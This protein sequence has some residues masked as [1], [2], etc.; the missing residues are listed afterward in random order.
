MRHFVVVS[1][2]AASMA[3]LSAC[4]MQ[5]VDAK[6][7]TVTYAYTEENFDEVAMRAENYCESQY[8]L[9]ASLVDRDRTSSG[10]EATF[11]C[12]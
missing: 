3:V 12:E 8:G 10:R 2:A 1:M 5:Q 6:P 4:E 11:A 9:D 7:P